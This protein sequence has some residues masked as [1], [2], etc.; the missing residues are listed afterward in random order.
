MAS[1]TALVTGGNRGIGLGICRALALRGL[2]WS[3]AHERSGRPPGRGGLG[4]DGSDVAD[5]PLDVADPKAIDRC[6]RLLKNDG[7][8]IDV[9]VNN[10]GIYTAG[11][12]MSVDELCSTSPGW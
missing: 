2:A 7:V 6:R 10:A 1:R 9:L 8:A 11:E 3:W 4:A 5:H 12:A